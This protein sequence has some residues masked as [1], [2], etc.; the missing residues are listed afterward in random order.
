[1]N[2]N[3]MKAIVYREYGEPEVL[4]LEEIEKPIPKDDEVLVKIYAVNVN[5]GDLFIRKFNEVTPKKFNM[6][7]LFWLPTKIL[8]GIRK[9]K[10]NIVGSEYSGVIESI[11]KDVNNFKIGEHHDKMI[12]TQARH[13]W[14]NAKASLIYKDS[15]YLDYANHG[16]EFLK[17]NMWDTEHGGFY[18][19]VTKKGEPILRHG[20][21]KTAYGNSF[22]IY[23]LA[24]LYKAS[25]NPEVLEYAKKTFLWLEE[26]SHDADLK[27]YFQN[28]NL[29]GSPII[30][31]E[32]EPSTSNIGYKDQNSSIHLLEAFTALYEVWPDELLAERL[33]EMLL[34]IR[35]T[36]VTEKGY[37]TLFFKTDWTPISYKNTSKENIQKHYYLN[38]VSFGHD[39]EIAYLM[40]EA[41]HALGWKNDSITL[42]KAKL[43][44]DHTVKNG[45]DKKTGGLYDGGYYYKDEDSISII[46]DN[47][48][49]WAQAEGLNSLL[50]MN[51][52]FPEDDINYKAE[53]D[54]LWS[55]TK[56]NFIDDEFGGWHEWGI[57]KTP[58]S[59]TALK[60][61]IWKSTYHNFRA[62][63]NC[64][65]VLKKDN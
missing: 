57:D 22:A 62:L 33:E 60:G 61:H 14:V 1:M 6:P 39:I 48:N 26:H 13:I 46:N 21:E 53:F 40:L 51:D 23:G 45:I 16:F 55:Y 35:D 36:I 32:E 8:L 5:F 34:L 63:I 28:L 18:N 3:K 54:N 27:G 65:D 64:I 4:K 29:D 12:V 41:S 2:S 42:Q 30:R 56:T 38:H 37:M 20:E 49:W 10:I 25:Q 59:E 17:N 31:T 50:I 15:A 19:I 58:E 47:K 43:L 7:F 52:L 9:P 44:V 24:T 11:G